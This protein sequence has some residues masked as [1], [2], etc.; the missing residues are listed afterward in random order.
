[1]IEP[2]QPEDGDRN[3]VANDGLGHGRLREFKI[4]AFYAE[5]QG[6][7]PGNQVEGVGRQGAE[8]SRQCRVK[9]EA[10]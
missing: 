5:R 7:Q 1:M 9:V 8:E 10:A 6:Q 4:A 3:D 2:Q